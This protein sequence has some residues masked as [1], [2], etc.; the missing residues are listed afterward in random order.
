MPTM[1]IKFDY[2]ISFIPK[3]EMDIFIYC[4]IINVTYHVDFITPTMC[5]KFY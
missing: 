1:C 4:N 2:H 5:I 3:F